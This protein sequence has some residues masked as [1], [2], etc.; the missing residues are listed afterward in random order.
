LRVV[1]VDHNESEQAIGALEEAEIIE[2]L[3][4]HRLGNPSTRAP[5]RFTVDIVGST[6]TLVSERIEDAGLSAP[7][8]IA[9]V[10][11]SGLISDTL[12]LTSP[13]TTKRDH[14]AAERLA[15]WAFSWE[16]ALKGETM[17]SFGEQVLKAG[18]GLSTRDPDEIVSTDLKIYEAGGLKFAISQAEVTS[19]MQIGK[20]REA[21]GIALDG[22]RAKQNLDFAML[23]V[24]DVV[25][26]SSRLL[27]S[28]APIILDELPYV[29]QPDGTRHATGMVSRKKQL[30]PVILG[31]LEG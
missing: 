9:G 13:T 16:S 8:D 22:L 3:D 19:L 17:Q 1:L 30:L 6:S 20:H 11:L 5:I 28:D 7:S 2:I 18:A 29:Q 24:T 14:L 25:R 31:L 12:L 23:M 27:I 15:R 21:L 4:H 26:G 10:L